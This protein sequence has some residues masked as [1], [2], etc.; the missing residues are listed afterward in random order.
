M[1]L[2][3]VT[4][5]FKDRLLGSEPDNEPQ[6]RLQ[7]LK[8]QMLAEASEGE[9]EIGQMSL[10]EEQKVG[11]TQ[12]LEELNTAKYRTEAK[13]RRLSFLRDLSASL[14][15]EQETIPGAEAVQS[16]EP[17]R[18]SHQT[19]FLE[20]SPA[21]MMDQVA[22]LRDK[23]ENIHERTEVEWTTCEQMEALLRKTKDSTLREKQKTDQLKY[24][25]KRL[26]HRHGEILTLQ[27]KA[28]NESIRANHQAFKASE[29]SVQERKAAEEKLRAKKALA[30]SLKQE[31]EGLAESAAKRLLSERVGIRQELEVKARRTA[32]EIE[33]LTELHSQQKQ[34]LSSHRQTVQRSQAALTRIHSYLLLRLLSQPEPQALD[35]SAILEAFRQMQ[36]QASSLNDQFA[37]LTKQESELKAKLEMLRE[38]RK[39]MEGAANDCE[40][41]QTSLARYLPDGLSSSLKQL[42]TFSSAS[43]ED[44]TAARRLRQDEAFACSVLISS[45]ETLQKL[46]TYARY[47]GKHVELSTEIE[48]ILTRTKENAEEGRLLAPDPRPRLGARR[49]TPR[50][51]SKVSGLDEELGDTKAEIASSPMLRLREA[52]VEAFGDRVGA[53]EEVM[54]TVVEILPV[55][56]T[57]GTVRVREVVEKGKEWSGDSVRGWTLYMVQYLLEEA[58]SH[59]RTRILQS[60]STSALLLKAIQDSFHFT[61]TYIDQSVL[62]DSQKQAF[63]RAKSQLLAIHA[64][65]QQK[66]PDKLWELLKATFELKLRA[67]VKQKRGTLALE[68][69]FTSFVVKASLKIGNKAEEEA[70][71]RLPVSLPLSPVRVS[72]DQ[73]SEEVAQQAELRRFQ[74]LRPSPSLTRSNS[75]FM[76]PA[77]SSI[78]SMRRPQDLEKALLEQVQGIERKIK[79]IKM[80]EREVGRVR[81]PAVRTRKRL[82]GSV[83]LIRG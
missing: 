49:L 32:A 42:Q 71:P 53:I 83:E 44:R 23:L 25:Q 12:L 5:F 10:S 70:K 19:S 68:S 3:N 4:S 16:A 28:S 78:S 74:R 21:L 67:L 9:G 55:R 33:R 52:F 64:G 66:V 81:L 79:G 47:I 50:K 41:L 36:F 14:Q 15:W 30:G 63:F 29:E 6:M 62:T 75:D 43:R 2:P 51:P 77:I 11:F 40:A 80:T 17:S 73:E 56:V 34:V 48:Q 18:I 58:H 65:K 37:S 61:S 27:A 31:V 39:T 54:M 57:M 22:Q 72:Q 59:L 24:L 46:Q 38:E 8:V 35:L 69:D 76:H 7:A 13:K 1:S 82:G 26:F 60:L 45:S 20:F